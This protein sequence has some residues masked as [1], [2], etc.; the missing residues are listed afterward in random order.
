MPPLGWA[1]EGRAGSSA[2]NANTPAMVSTSAAHM[3]TI[4]AQPL[5]ILTV[6]Y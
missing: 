6:G 5:V 2:G 1:R 4:S 3:A